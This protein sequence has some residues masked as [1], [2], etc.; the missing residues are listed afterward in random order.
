MKLTF[1]KATVFFVPSKFLLKFFF[2]WKISKLQLLLE[3]GIGEVKRCRSADENIINAFLGNT[4]EMNIYVIIIYNDLKKK[5]PLKKIEVKVV[6]RKR[7]REGE[8]ER[9]GELIA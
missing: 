8:K 6:I 4:I 7:D 2:N 9:N 3:N 5:R 1:V